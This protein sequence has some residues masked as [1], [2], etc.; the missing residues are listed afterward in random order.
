MAGSYFRLI[1]S[2]INELKAQGPFR[3]CNESREEEEDIKADQGR[4]KRVG[5]I[6][7]ARSLLSGAGFRVQGSG[8][9]VQG[10]GF[11]VQGS[12]FRVQG[13]GFRVQC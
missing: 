3:T 4:R 5:S 2:C 10:S 8:F 6:A 13:L 9:R 1:D 11:R 7:R 12:G